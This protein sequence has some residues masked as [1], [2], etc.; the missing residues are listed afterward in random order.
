MY[1]Y[2]FVSNE[3]DVDEEFNDEVYNPYIYKNKL[4]T[5]RSNNECNI[6]I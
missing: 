6:N 5:I 4:I 3:K 1:P 2:N